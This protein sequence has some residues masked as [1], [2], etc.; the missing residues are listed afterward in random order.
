MLN[1]SVKNKQIFFFI[2]FELDRKVSPQPS[3]LIN[4]FY[5]YF[6][7]EQKMGLRYASSAVGKGKSTTAMTT[8]KCEPITAPTH[9][10][11]Q[12]QRRKSIQQETVYN[13][14]PRRSLAS[15]PAITSASS[16]NPDNLPHFPV[17]KLEDT[18]GKYLKSVQPLL[19]ADKFQQTVK[20]VDAFTKGIGNQLQQKLKERADKKENWLSDW[21]LTNAYLA[22]RSPV[23]I[24][25]NPGLYFP[26][27]FFENDFQWCRYAARVIW[28]SLRYKQMIDYNEIPAE[29][30]GKV[31]LDMAQYKKIYG[32][33][34]IPARD[35]DQIAYHPKSRHIVV[36]YRNAFYKVPVYEPSS[37]KFLS[38]NQ[39][40]EQLLL[41]VKQN[42]NENVAI[43]LLTTEH[44]ET[45]AVAYERLVKDPVNKASIDEISG[46][47][48]VV[49]LDSPLPRQDPNED[50]DVASHQLIHGGGSAQNSGN[51]W[52]DKT[53]QFIVNRNGINGI[54]YEHSPAEGQPI[55][56][57]TDFILKHV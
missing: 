5:F 17:P 28:A 37:D 39:L 55:A 20:V 38:E 50:M 22:Y 8:S 10:L 51:R 3:Y 35:V 44:R 42:S 33:C 32:T 2:L 41:I 43:G 36:A 52:Y 56:V 53:L 45:L 16:T 14:A 11:T 57:L 49:C 1:N 34:R 9:V 7:F 40:T 4:F 25:S 46:S 6:S 13:L 23:V 27:R 12:P 48:F 15:A 18:L 24:H 19:P 47:L 21:W 26:T 30:A 54:T 29:T 31:P